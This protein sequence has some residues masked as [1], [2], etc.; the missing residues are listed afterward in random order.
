MFW[1]LEISFKTGFTVLIYHRRKL[2][3]LIYLFIIIFD[4]SSLGSLNSGIL[5][6]IHFRNIPLQYCIKKE[7]E[8]EI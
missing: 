3:G 6:I 1:T 5:A 4:I 2:L 8:T 7:A